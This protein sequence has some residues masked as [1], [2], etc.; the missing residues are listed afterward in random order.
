MSRKKEMIILEPDGRIHTE[1]FASAPMRCPYCNGR[2][3]F[4]VD[5]PEGPAEEECPDC[6]GAGEVYAFVT[7]EWK[8]NKR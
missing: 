2:G 4:P 8:P 3:G 7:I 5:T 6:K 1:G